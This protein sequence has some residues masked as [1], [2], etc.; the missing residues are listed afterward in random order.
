MTVAPHSNCKVVVNGVPITAKTKLQHLV[1]F[2][3]RPQDS[4]GWTRESA[5]VGT[6]QG[7]GLRGDA[8]V[9]AVPL[10]DLMCT[11]CV[12]SGSHLTSLRLTYET[13]G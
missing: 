10:G 12:F 11:C 8:V 3:V 5:R 2:P 1:N 4:L 7:E 6:A 9:A 13:E